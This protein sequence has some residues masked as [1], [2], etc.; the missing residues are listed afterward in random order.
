MWQ[1]FYVRALDIANERI[2]EAER[3]RWARLARSGSARRVAFGGFRRQGALVAAG[4]ARRL[5]ECVA[6]E[7]LAAGRSDDRL[8]SAT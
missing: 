1:I 7:A 5:D 8:G 4:L 6:R 2:V 3:E